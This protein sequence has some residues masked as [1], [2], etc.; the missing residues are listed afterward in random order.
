MPFLNIDGENA[1][2]NKVMNVGYQLRTLTGTLDFGSYTTGGIDLDLS[3]YFSKGVK[4]VN[5]FPKSGYL[6]EYDKVNKK[7]K[8]FYVDAG[9]AADGPMVEVANGADL[10]GLTG[11]DFVAYGWG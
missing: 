1:G 9:L 7:V 5:V 4:K 8:V 3:N 6:F 2:M 11:V 10:S